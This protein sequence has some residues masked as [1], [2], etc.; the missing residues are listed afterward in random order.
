MPSTSY[1]DS[2]VVIAGCPTGR[3]F[4]IPLS[5][6][7]SYWGLFAG[8]L[9]RLAFNSRLPEHSNLRLALISYTVMPLMFVVMYFWRRRAILTYRATR[10][11]ISRV[12]G[13]FAENINGMRVVQ[14]FGREDRNSAGARATLEKLKAFTATATAPGIA[15]AAR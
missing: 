15:Q 10:I 11:A 12:T 2:S 7:R 9:R 4:L 13:N 5:P 3:S 14:S 1:S 6:T 8:F